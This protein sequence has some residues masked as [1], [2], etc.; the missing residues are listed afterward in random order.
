MPSTDGS[1]QALIASKLV[2]EII[3][4]QRRSVTADKHE[5]LLVAKNLFTQPLVLK[6]Q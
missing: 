6:L 5:P 3:C 4:N 1:T 2:I